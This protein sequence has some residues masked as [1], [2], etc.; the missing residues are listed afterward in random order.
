MIITKNPVI[1]SLL[2]KFVNIVVRKF[3]FSHEHQYLAEGLLFFPKKINR[4]K[5]V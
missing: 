5:E 1:N 2:E 3:I 4:I